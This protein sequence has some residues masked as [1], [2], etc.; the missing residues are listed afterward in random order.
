MSI[1]MYFLLQQACEREVNTPYP[2]SIRMYIHMATS[3]KSKAKPVTYTIHEIK[4]PI[5]GPA[6]CLL[7]QAYPSG[8]TTGGKESVYNSYLV[9]AVWYFV[10]N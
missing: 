1:R 7:T 10:M 5:W 3:E 9:T 6:I 8:S 2:N 4:I